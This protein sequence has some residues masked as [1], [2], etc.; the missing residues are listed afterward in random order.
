MLFGEFVLFR[1][2]ACTDSKLLDDILC[3]F[4]YICRKKI[5]WKI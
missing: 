1:K 3:F 4:S 5:E 2:H